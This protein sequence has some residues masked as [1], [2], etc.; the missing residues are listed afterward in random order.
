M[1]FTHMKPHVQNLITS[2]AKWTDV[3]SVDY[4]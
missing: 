2:P 3:L 1:T 4:K